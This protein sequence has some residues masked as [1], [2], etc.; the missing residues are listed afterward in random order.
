MFT[1]LEGR[2][3]ERDG[4]MRW[5]Y[6][7]ELRRPVSERERTVQITLDSTL[8]PMRNSAVQQH[9]KP[10]KLNRKVSFLWSFFALRSVF[11]NSALLLLPFAA[12]IEL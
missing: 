10:T 2:E 8:I 3:R 6:R 9:N 1:I 4:N 7:A 5:G 12:T 11:I